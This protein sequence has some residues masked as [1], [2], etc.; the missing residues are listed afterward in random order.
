VSSA[1]ITFLGFIAG[2]T[3]LFGLP[4]GRIRNASPKL[5]AFLNATAVG[6]LVFLLIDV[7][8]HAQEPVDTAL[9]AAKA[10]HSGPWTTFFG[11]AALLVVG[12]GI[13]LM[14]LAFYERWMTGRAMS[15]NASSGDDPERHRGA[16]ERGAGGRA[17]VAVGDVHGVA[18][19]WPSTRF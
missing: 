18:P 11:L 14:S 17:E 19:R 10:D 3:I 7:L 1:S 13:G 12:V 6:V 15:A 4:V 9:T 16:V 5:R 8:S 2:A